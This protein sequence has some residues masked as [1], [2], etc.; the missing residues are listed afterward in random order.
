MF[1]KFYIFS[2]FSDHLCHGGRRCRDPLLVARV[3]PLAHCKVTFCLDIAVVAAA[4]V[5]V[6]VV[7]VVVVVVVVAVVIVVFVVILF[8]YVVSAVNICQSDQFTPE[9]QKSK[10]K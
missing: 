3:P 7:A 9:V 8:C 1:D 4:V 10:F 5:V 6:V 2:S